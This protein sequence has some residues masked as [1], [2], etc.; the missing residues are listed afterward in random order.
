MKGLKE[1]KKILIFRHGSLGDTVVAL[2][3]FYLIAKTFPEAQRRILT[4]IPDNQNAVSL[5]AV[6]EH[7]GLVHGYFIYSAG[8]KTAENVFRLRDEI[9]RW[10][11]EVLIYLA[12]P[13]GAWSAWRDTLFFKLCGIKNLV[14][15]PYT[16]KL[17]ENQWLPEKKS[18]EHESKRLARCL[19]AL[20]GISLD[21]PANWD[22]RLTQE[23]EARAL[24]SLKDWKARER[25]IACN[26]SAKVKAKDWG[27]ENWRELLHRL[28]LV[29]PDL[30]IVMM[31]AQAGAEESEAIAHAWR[32]PALN[33]C[34]KL[35]LRESAGVIKRAIF[36]LGHDSGPMH[37]A[38]A[39]RVPCVAV[40][41]ECRK[42]GVW[43][44]YG[45]GHKVICHGTNGLSRVA[46]SVDEVFEAARQMAEG[47]R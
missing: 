35:T 34:G 41:V 22:L 10:K 13:R 4:T 6:L 44:P 25:F 11:P 24:G 16:K 46:V 36:Y 28:S 17:R 20:G 21:D 40:F 27:K 8:L 14:G 47:K 12:E 1:I 33:L 3:S 32:G 19:E 9:K 45:S 7:T 31:G 23:E 15:V 37:L 2:P 39:A 5:S 18:F 42:P 38:A 29:Y 30:G 43:F 26:V